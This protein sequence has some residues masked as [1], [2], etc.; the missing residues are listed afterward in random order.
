M[1]PSRAAPDRGRRAATPG[2]VAGRDHDTLR[3]DFDTRALHADLTATVAALSD[4]G[5][6]VLG[7]RYHHHGRVFPLPRPVARALD[8]RIDQLNLVIDGVLQEHNARCLD[9]AG[10]PACYE[11]STWS[12]DRLHPSALGHRLLAREL[13][14][15]LAATGYALE[16]SRIEDGDTVVPTGVEEMHWLLTQGVPWLCRRSRDLVPFALTAVLSGA[17]TSVHP[18][19]HPVGDGRRRV[20]RQEVQARHG[21]LVPARANAGTAPSLTSWSASRYCL[22]RP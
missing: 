21:D 4:V 16:P 9:L 15:M 11:A 7:V 17:L 1:R 10:I 2:R 8:R 20:L 12:V 22:G 6:T 3:S 19:T 14:C 13:T 5:A 18:A